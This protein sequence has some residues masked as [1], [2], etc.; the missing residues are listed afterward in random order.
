MSKTIH[1][2]NIVMEDFVNYKVPS[3]FLI[4]HQCNWKCCHEGGFSETV[5]Q[6]QPLVSQPTKE[7]NISS[8]YNAYVSNDITKA[9]VLGG[10]EPIL[11][12]DEVY[13]LVSYFREN[14]CKDYFVIYTGY[15]P[16]EIQEQ[17]DKLKQ[18][19]N[20]IVKFGRYVPG[21]K[22]HYDDV[23]GISLASDNQYAEVIS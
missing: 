21:Y 4:T 10:L 18:L 15:Y 22:K 9:V 5:C 6:N 16:E 13:N 19:P 3:M 8:I 1:L 23:L 17:L 11:Q 12:F 14:G 7:Y 20:I 2:K